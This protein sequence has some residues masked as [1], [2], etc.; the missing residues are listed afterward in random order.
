MKSTESIS[1]LCPYTDGEGVYTARALLS[2]VYPD[3]LFTSYCEEGI[4]F[5][6]RSHPVENV[7][8]GE[9]QKANIYIYPNPANDLIYIVS[10]NMDDLKD[11][12]ISIYDMKGLMI[13]R[14]QCNIPCTSG[15]D[16]SYLPYGFY[17][18]KVIPKD[19][20][21]IYQKKLIKLK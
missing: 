3:S 13:L 16:I 21:T 19:C 5:E 6:N 14:K 7:V 18:I 11:A 17:I 2:M 12:E 9:E 1:Q 20:N 15:I 10:D 4:E 8:P